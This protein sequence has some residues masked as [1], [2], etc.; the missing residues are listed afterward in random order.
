MINMRAKEAEKAAQMFL[1]KKHEPEL[2]ESDDMFFDAKEFHT[3]NKEVANILQ[4]TQ[5]TENQNKAAGSANLD[6]NGTWGDDD[7][8]DIDADPMLGDSR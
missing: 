6:V 4:S 7:L 1:K 3:S 2:A 8:I 5:Q